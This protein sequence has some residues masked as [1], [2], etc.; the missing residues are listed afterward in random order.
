MLTIIKQVE[1]PELEMAVEEIQAKLDRI[2]DVVEGT[3][4]IEFKIGP[5]SEQKEH[6]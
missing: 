4:H 5:V 6:P 3:N 1:V 2:L